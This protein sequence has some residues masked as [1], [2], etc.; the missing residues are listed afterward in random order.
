M[1]AN[2]VF[3]S[4]CRFVLVGVFRGFEVVLYLSRGQFFWVVWFSCGCR[5]G[6]TGFPLRAERR[7]EVRRSFLCF[8]GL[9]VVWDSFV[10][11]SF[12]VGFVVAVSSRVVWDF[13]FSED[14]FW[15]RVSLVGI[16]GIFP[17]VQRV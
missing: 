16:G 14:H 12:L 8:R 11:Q 4:F 2:R 3:S 6:A 7:V 5:C 17:F 9:I 13:V 1:F 10:V 15:F